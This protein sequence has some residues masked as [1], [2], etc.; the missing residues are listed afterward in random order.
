MLRFGLIGRNLAHSFS[1]SYFND[2]FGR[3]GIHARY[4]NVE[5][6]A[7]TDFM[8][9]LQRQSGFV[10]FNV[11]VPYKQSIMP[12]ID[13]IDQEAREVGA[14][15]TICCTAN[16]LHGYNTDVYGFRESIKPF[17]RHGQE[18]ALI[19]GTGGAASAVAHVLRGIGLDV[20]FV[21]R[22][23]QGEKQFGYNQLNEF[24]MKHFLLIVNAT[25]I[26]TYP[27]VE[28]KPPLPYASLGAMHT[29]YDLVYNP[30]E[31]AFLREGKARGALTINGADMLRLQAERS[32]ELW[33]RHHEG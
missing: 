31:T 18:R 33:M 7:I 26:G 23:P 1:A 20:T 5:L 29:L 3:E 24:V 17:L 9:W 14:V 6:P 25:P 11:T 30:E 4:E 27:N 21:S 15:N 22:E 32:W 12:Y 19:L 28:Q 13:E 16:G 2:R 8:P 10:G